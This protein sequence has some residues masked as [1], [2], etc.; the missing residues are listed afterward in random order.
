LLQEQREWGKKRIGDILLGSGL[1]TRDVLDRAL[2]HQKLYG[3][4]LTSFLL[5]YGF[6]DEKQLAHCLCAQFRVPYLPLEAYDISDEIIRLIPTDIAEKYWVLPV[7]KQG[8]ALTVVMIDPL[9]TKAIKELEELTGLV[10]IP[11]VGIISEIASAL[12]IHYKLFVKDTKTN[13]PPFFINTKT[14]VGKERRNS[15]R[16]ETKID[17]QFPAQGYYLKSQTIDVSRDGFAFLSERSIPLGSFLNIEVNL[18]RDISPFPIAAVTQVVRCLPKE[19][20]VF[21][22]GVKTLKIIKDEVSLIINFAAQ[23]G[24][25]GA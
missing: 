15:I 23:H 8:N 24:A 5:H 2:E 11:F 18:P 19:E 20:N 4:N 16:Y 13:V 1:I 21:E 3:G 12:Q 10:I 22:I 9:D 7:E 17:V 25:G 6:I 14:Y